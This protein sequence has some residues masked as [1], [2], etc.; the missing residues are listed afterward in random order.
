M[1]R[2]IMLWFAVRHDA[3][4]SELFFAFRVPPDRRDLRTLNRDGLLLNLL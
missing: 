1:Y 3:A 2:I 4:P